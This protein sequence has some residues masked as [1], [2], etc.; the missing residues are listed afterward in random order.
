VRKVWVPSEQINTNKEVLL[1][2]FQVIRGAA[3]QLRQVDIDN[4]S[5][6]KSITGEP[7]R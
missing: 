3:T 5:F 7:V 6:G 2:R 4:D 1:S